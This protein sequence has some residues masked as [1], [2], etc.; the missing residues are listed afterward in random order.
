M[1]E[2]RTHKDRG[3]VGCEWNKRNTL[4]GEGGVTTRGTGFIV[5]G[6]PLKKRCHCEGVPPREMSSH[7]ERREKGGVRIQKC[8]VKILLRILLR[9]HNLE[10]FD[11]WSILL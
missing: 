1:R 8:R 2:R 5:V 10:L 3:E 9:Q 6:V 4:K 7:I 11:E